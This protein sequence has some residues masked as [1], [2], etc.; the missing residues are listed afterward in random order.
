MSLPALFPQCGPALKRGGTLD[1][2]ACRWA[3]TGTAKGQPRY[4]SMSTVQVQPGRK[5]KF[6]IF[7]AWRMSN[8]QKLWAKDY[9]FKAWRIPIY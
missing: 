9:G 6:Y 2:S 5:P 1:P 8:G 4:V 3:T 7:R